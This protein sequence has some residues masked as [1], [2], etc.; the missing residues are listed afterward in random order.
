MWPAMA[1]ASVLMCVPAS[2]QPLPDAGED[3]SIMEEGPSGENPAGSVP[4][5]ET[6]V[7][8]AQKHS[9]VS[10][11]DLERVVALDVTPSGIWVALDEE[12]IVWQRGFDGVWKRRWNAVDPMLIG[13]GLDDEAVL[14]EAEASFGEI[15]TEFQSEWELEDEDVDLDPA[16]QDALTEELVERSAL[17]HSENM[18]ERGKGAALGYRRMVWASSETP[19][20]VIV[21]TETGSWLSEN[22]GESWVWV[23]SLAPTESIIELKETIGRDVWL[24]ATVDGVRLSRDHGLSWAPVPGVVGNNWSH[25]FAIDEGTIF[26]AGVA[27]VFHSRDGMT[28]NRVDTAGV[29]E[30]E[31]LFL[32]PDPEWSAGF[33]VGTPS[34][35]WRSDDN[36]KTRHRVSRNEMKGVGRVIAMERP[37][38]LLAAGTDGVWESIDGGIR[39]Q[40][41]AEGLPGPEVSSLVWS[42]NEE[43]VLAGPYGV[44]RLTRIGALPLRAP[45]P[46][47]AANVP[48]LS[49]VMDWS[50]RRVGGNLRPAMVTRAM[51]MRM[52]APRLRIQGELERDRSLSADLLAKG[53]SGDSDLDWKVMS[54]LC[55]GNCDSVSWVTDSVE[56]TFDVMVIDG[57]VYNSDNV[58]AFAPAAASVVE[59]LSQYRTTTAEHVAE[60]YFSRMRLE[61]AR[62]GV[63]G[64][65]LKER[66]EHE[67]GVQ[68]VTAHIDI[69]TDGLFSRALEA[70]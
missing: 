56:N 4:P 54:E 69:F 70:R 39:W 51:T 29:L 57:D 6:F 47:Q 13:D 62:A 63:E 22:H 66:V 43:F 18:S 31:T 7:P 11:G 15:L 68:E 35:L 65:S 9:W 49:L 32:T 27:G 53:N 21:S 48:P 5:E 25:S 46:K 45:S 28:W 14:L 58:G 42:Q 55:F 37:G 8:W 1:V 24:A 34:G 12:G 16:Q 64:L 38:H 19:G 33:W 3:T 30:P 10:M 67:L 59:K 20:I 17:D 44:F 36:G 26:A 23:E 61:S 2:A 41:L 40:R 52:Y 60:L 50:T